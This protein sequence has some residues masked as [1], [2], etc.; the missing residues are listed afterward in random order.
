MQCGTVIMVPR[1]PGP[2]RMDL[3][4]RGRRRYTWWKWDPDPQPC[5]CEATTSTIKLLWHPQHSL[6]EAK[7]SNRTPISQNWGRGSEPDT[8][9]PSFA[10]LAQA[11]FI[12]GQTCHPVLGVA[13]CFQSRPMSPS[14]RRAEEKGCGCFLRGGITHHLPFYSLLVRETQHR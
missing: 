5:R 12:S 3:A 7:I 4:N 13:D 11:A 2:I 8:F 10:N 1:L 6:L 9:N 14:K